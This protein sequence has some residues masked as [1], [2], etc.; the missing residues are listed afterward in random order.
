MK[1]IVVPILEILQGIV[2]G[3]D[4]R[5]EDPIHRDYKMTDI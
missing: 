5:V 2:L 3:R 1:F 4:R